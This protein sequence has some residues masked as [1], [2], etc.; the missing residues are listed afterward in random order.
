[1]GIAAAN[2]HVGKG[3]AAADSPGYTE[4]CPVEG[5]EAAYG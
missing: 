4:C 2:N 1:M 5:K 3:R